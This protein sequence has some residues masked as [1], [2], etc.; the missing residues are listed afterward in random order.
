MRWPVGISR[1]GQI[2]LLTLF[3]LALY[4]GIRALPVRECSFLHY[5]DYLSQEGAIEECGIGEV[6]FLDLSQLRYP[7]KAALHPDR[8]PTSGEPVAFTFTLQNSRN[9]PIR[10]EEL[11]VSHTRRLHLLVVDPSLQDYQHLHPEPTGLPGEF[12]FQMTPRFGGLYTAYF[13][14]IPLRSARRTLHAETFPVAGVPATSTAGK[15]ASTLCRIDG[16]DFLLASKLQPDGVYEMELKVAGTGHPL[17]FEPVMGAYAHVVAFAPGRLGFAHLHPLNPFL[18]Q[19]DPVRPDLRFR[20]AP[21]EIAQYEIWAQV[22]W[23]GEERFLPFRL[24]FPQG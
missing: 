12:R 10:D 15:S 7:V 2:L 13:D 18:D 4:L 23:N 8:P 14:F 21:G 6:D 16:I 9:D 24:H 19:Q 17:R 22:Q 3:F 20:F 5:K 11:A 1:Q